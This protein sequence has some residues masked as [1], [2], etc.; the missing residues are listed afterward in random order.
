MLEVFFFFRGVFFFPP[1]NEFIPIGTKVTERSARRCFTRGSSPE[2]SQNVGSQRLHDTAPANQ[3]LLMWQQ[4][5]KHGSMVLPCPL[6]SQS[7]ILW[8]LPVSMCKGPAE[9]L[10]LWG[11]RGG[12]SDFKNCFRS[13]CLQKCFNQLYRCWQKCVAAEGHYFEGK[14]HLRAS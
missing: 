2:A 9:G 3:S 4:V 11:C 14:L 7:R 13:S 12:S 8:F 6:Y 10:S 5:I 1:C